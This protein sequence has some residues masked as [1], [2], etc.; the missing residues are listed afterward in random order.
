MIAEFSYLVDLEADSSV[1]RGRDRVDGEFTRGILQSN[2]EDGVDSSVG[3]FDL[4]IEV[5]EGGSKWNIFLDR[6]FILG[7]VE[8]WRFI[9][10]ISNSDGQVGCGAGAIIIS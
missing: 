10:D 9:V 7:F 1:T 3:V 5:G 8:C 6:H 4:H 2:R